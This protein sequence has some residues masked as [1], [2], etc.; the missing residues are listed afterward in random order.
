MSSQIP[1]IKIICVINIVI[2]LLNMLIEI[3]SMRNTEYVDGSFI[4]ISKIQR[5]KNYIHVSDDNKEYK[6]HHQNSWV[7]R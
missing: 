7:V 3:I 4:S 1:E 2:R 5:E 6:S